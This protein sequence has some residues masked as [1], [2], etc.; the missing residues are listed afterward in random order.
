MQIKSLSAILIFILCGIV[1]FSQTYADQITEYRTEYK[2]GFL[3]DAN[4]PL[5]KKDLKYL[6]F[7]EPDSR[8]VVT[9]NFKRTE[10]ALPFDM[11]TSS[12]KMKEYIKYG[13]AT[14]LLHDTAFTI[15]VYQSTQLRE[16]EQYKNYLFIPFNDATNS[17]TT[18][19][20]GRY[21]DLEIDEIKNNTLIID[22]NKAYNPYCVYS[23]GYS[24]PV[25]PKENFLDV[26]INAG[27]KNFLKKH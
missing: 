18:Y 12:G 23:D 10:D 14:F 25:P 11:P 13:E 2:Q 20:G 24:C 9:A 17:V 16:F 1:C 21:M 8:Y 26:Q 5:K 19:G 7:F 4:S 6:D 3:K 22:F 15:S 27:E